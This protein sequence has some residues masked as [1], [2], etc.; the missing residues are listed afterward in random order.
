MQKVNAAK[1]ILTDPEKRKI[2]DQHGLEGI[3]SGMTNHGF[4]SQS[5]RVFLLNKTIFNKS[6]L[7]FFSVI[8]LLEELHGGRHRREDRR[9]PQGTDIKHFLKFGEKKI[10][11]FY[12]HFFF[13]EFL[14]KIYIWEVQK[15]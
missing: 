8:D 10:F 9:K 7:L 14:S 6:I 15:Q 3:K 2:Y 13:S 12:F 4:H 11:P 5:S 1:E